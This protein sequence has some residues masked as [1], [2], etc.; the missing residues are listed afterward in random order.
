MSKQANAGEEINVANASR[1]F[2]EDTPKH[3]GD[4]VR[5]SVPF[6][7]AGHDV[8]LQVSDYFVQPDSVCC[9]LGVS[10]GVLLRKLAARHETGVRWFG[11]HRDHD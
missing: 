2:G 3:F 7:A 1:T 9:E 11:I 6:Y 4:D 10:T 8:V 5:R